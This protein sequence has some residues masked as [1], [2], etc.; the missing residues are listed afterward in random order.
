ME[1]EVLALAASA[2]LSL[3]A[4]GIAGYLAAK[5]ASARLERALA[6]LAEAARLER[7]LAREA[8]KAAARPKRRY[9]VFEAFSE[10]PLD[11]GRLES[12]LKEAFSRLFGEA[13][14]AASGLSLIDF[15]PETMRGVV[16]VRRDYKIHALAAMA[17]L[18]RVDGRRVM[19]APLAV[20]GTLKRARRRMAKP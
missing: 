2:T 4:G 11:A 3:L 12:A 5:K 7:E 16:R 14:L 6:R 18:R 19:I 1:A 10:G 9:I 20:S 15:N 8:R 17:A 13:A